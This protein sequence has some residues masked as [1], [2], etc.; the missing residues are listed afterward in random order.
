MDHDPATAEAFYNVG[1]F[2]TVGEAKA[3]LA[4]LTMEQSVM[5]DVTKGNPDLAA[6]RLERKRRQ[7]AAAKDNAKALLQEEKQHRTRGNTYLGVFKREDQNRIAVSLTSKPDKRT[8]AVFVPPRVCP[9][10]GR[11]FQRSLYRV[12]DGGSSA[13]RHRQS[14]RSAS[15]RSSTG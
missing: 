7:T 13:K 14:S 11:D 3:Q 5:T 4:K 8:S 9:G 10:K 15:E 12:I 1:H 2:K 6:R